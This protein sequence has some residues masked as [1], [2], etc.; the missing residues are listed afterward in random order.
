[1][2]QAEDPADRLPSTGGAAASGSADL[3]THQGH[4]FHLQHAEPDTYD[5]GS[6]HNTNEE[7]FPILAGQD[8]SAVLAHLEPGGIRE[9]HWHPSAWELD[10]VLT[11]KLRFT[12]LETLDYTETFDAAGGDLIFLP[13]GG[14]HYFE[15]T[16]QTDANSL[17]VFNTSATEPR[18]DIGLV[19]ALGALPP[20]AL[21][22]PIF[23][24]PPEAFHH[25]PRA[26]RRVGRSPATTGNTTT[27]PQRSAQD[28]HHA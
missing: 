27:Q 20:A 6:L 12:I 14:L 2:S 5:G 19:A 28:H 9:G 21:L 16:G 10:F 4:L 13:Q 3:D 8:A 11:G 26:V 1:M 25:I 18:D 17:I 15:N 23:G 24:T 22:G 7:T